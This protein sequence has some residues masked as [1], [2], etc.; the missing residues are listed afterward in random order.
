MSETV[1][2][3]AVLVADPEAPVVFADRAA[4]LL[5]HNDTL[6]ITL[7]AMVADHSRAP[8]ALHRKVAGTVILPIASAEAL[9]KLI[10]SAVENAKGKR[11][12]PSTLQ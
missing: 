1:T 2:Q 9:A 10:L 5:W 8:A 4:G 11:E 7:E 12:A 3:Q 6:R